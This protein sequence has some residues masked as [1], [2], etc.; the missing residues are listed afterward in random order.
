[1]VATHIFEYLNRIPPGTDDACCLA[2]VQVLQSW[3]ASYKELASCIVRL[4][5]LPYNPDC[6][7]HCKDLKINYDVEF[8]YY[9]NSSNIA[10]LVEQQ[11]QQQVENKQLADMSLPI[12][13]PRYEILE[14]HFTLEHL[15]DSLVV[16]DFTPDP[17]SLA[18]QINAYRQRLQENKQNQ[19]PI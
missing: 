19:Q 15:P 10:L 5:S 8:H 14:T 2:N 13:L 9:K 16:E 7:E 17:Q 6:E 18:G 11:Q 12:T 3:F 1:M 4:L